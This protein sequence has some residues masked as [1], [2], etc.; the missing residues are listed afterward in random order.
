MMNRLNKSKQALIDLVEKGWLNY[1]VELPSVL[2]LYMQ[3]AS[4]A[5]INQDLASRSE[6][7]Q[8]LSIAEWSDFSASHLLH[9]DDELRVPNEVMLVCY[10]NQPF[11]VI[12]FI[13]EGVINERIVNQDVYREVGTRFAPAPDSFTIEERIRF[14]SDTEMS[15]SA[16]SDH[17]IA[18]DG[19]SLFSAFPNDFPELN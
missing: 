11:M 4:T 17:I 18:F 12:Q 14:F 3:P 13:N 19:I 5:L 1:S 7:L 15:V 6:I 9:I 16:S 2:F 8:D 10:R